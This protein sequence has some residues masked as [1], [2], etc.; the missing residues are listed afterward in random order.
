[1]VLPA[2]SVHV[3]LEW[4]AWVAITFM[5]PSKGLFTAVGAA[6]VETLPAMNRRQALKKS[7]ELSYLAPRM[8]ICNRPSTPQPTGLP[9]SF[10][11]TPHL[12]LP[13]MHLALLGAPCLRQQ[14][15]PGK[16]PKAT[17]RGVLGELR[18]DPSNATCQLQ[19]S[20]QVSWWTSS[21]A[22]WS[23]ARSPSSSGRG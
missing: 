4:L 18:D 21:S 10:R 5:K 9:R 15:V 1:M 22:S 20:S 19:T 8:A 23:V 11:T 12:D 3:A 2:S 16:L 14:P 17:E 6:S 7:L 13:L